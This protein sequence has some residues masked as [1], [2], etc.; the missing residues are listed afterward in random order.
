MHLVVPR[1]GWGW[2]GLYFFH[3][4]S[5]QQLGQRAT[6]WVAGFTDKVLLFCLQG[7]IA[8]LHKLEK[9]MRSRLGLQK[10]RGIDELHVIVEQSSIRFKWKK[11]VSYTAVYSWLALLEDFPRGDFSLYAVASAAAVVDS[12]AAVAMQPKE[13]A[14]AMVVQPIQEEAAAVALQTVE[15]EAELARIKPRIKLVKKTRVTQSK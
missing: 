3:S 6:N 5:F 4:G 9:C 13:E 10:L 2:S 12:A 8:G 11:E 1:V 14:T 15:E 7:S